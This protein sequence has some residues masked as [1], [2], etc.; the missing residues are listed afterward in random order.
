MVKR[1]TKTAMLL[2]ETSCRPEGV[3]FHAYSIGKS[4]LLHTPLGE[5]MAGDVK[6]G[7]MLEFELDTGRVLK[8]GR[9]KIKWPTR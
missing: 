4:V 8:I 5:L 1:K 2:P 7:Q 3:R 6:A 9:R